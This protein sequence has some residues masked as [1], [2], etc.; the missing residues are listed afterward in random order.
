MK[1]LCDN[2]DI[3]GFRNPFAREEFK[4]KY[5]CPKRT[6]I[7]SS[8]ISEIF[9]TNAQVKT[10]SNGVKNFVYV[11]SL[12]QRKHPTALISALANAYDN[13]LYK[14]TFIGDGK[15]E[16]VIREQFC[17]NNKNGEL[18]LTGRIPRPQVINYLK[19]S[20]VFVM[21]SES[22]TFGL[23]YL[24]AMAIGCITIASR[25][26]GV[27]GIIRDGE[28]GFLCNPGDEEELSRIIMKIRQMDRMAL[29]TI[30]N[31]SVKT[32]L[33]YTDEKVAETYLNAVSQ[34]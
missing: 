33:E 31:N 30:S 8:G 1:T 34:A 14:V 15:E 13:D 10:F 9:V 11:G 17:A 23:V 7:A 6:F 25:G 16:S 32:A 5:F 27:D 20:D 4:E 12:I 18:E 28:N 21:I 26:G 19:E 3:I 22:E 29:Q 2:L 24:E